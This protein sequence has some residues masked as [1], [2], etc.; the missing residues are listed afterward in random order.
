MQDDALMAT[1]TPREALRFSAG[2]RLPSTTTA[3]EIEGIV[4][5]LL[6]DLGL[7]SCAD[8]MIGGAMIK[9]IS[10]G[11]R[12]R[13]SVGIE[14]ITDPSLLFLDEPTSGLDSYSAF[15]LVKLLKE[16]AA[17]NCAVLCTIHQPSSEV[18]FL[19]DIVI[20]MKDGR[21]FYQGPPGDV[22]PFYE[23][24]GR[25]C[26]DDYNPSDY[27]MNLCQA[28][29]A[30]EL[31]KQGL[32]M[33]TPDAFRETSPSS[34]KFGSS[35]VDFHSESSFVK[36][37]TAIA[38]RE[39]VNAYR[40][41]PA[42][43]ARF[44]IT[45]LLGILYGLIFLG[46]CGKDN[47]DQ[48]NYNTHV[49]AISMV[50]IFGLFASG[51]AVM[52]SFPFERPMILREYA[53]GTYSVPA[54][55]ISKL[56]VEAPMTFVQFIVLYL[57]VY[58]MMDMQGD[59]ILLVLSTWGLGMVSNSVAMG[60]GCMV[61]DVKDVTELA[62]LMYVPQILFAG[63]FI[64]TDQIPIFLRWAQYLCSMKYAMNLVLMSEF[65]LDRDN[66]QGPAAAANCREIIES[67][68]IDPEIFYVYIILLF[69]L[70]IAFRVV[71]AMILIQKA[72]RFY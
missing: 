39:I 12:K 23:T 42:L 27:V 70:F 57:L 35:A 29:S 30:E 14:I 48:D 33:P 52:L 41:T 51:Q 13:T 47:G 62:P 58:F 54:Y 36:Q 63:F 10:G 6:E 71:G 45:T 20:Y 1:S 66:C 28:E 61:P 26:P 15:S 68:N 7:T 60:L 64:R 53:T 44:G 2:L 4:E 40:D 32:F 21:V 25:I 46:A 17:S 38:H 59:Y 67:N 31:D 34:R 11:Q 5:G 55:F 43:M 24:K 18:F 37:V 56:V 65:R 49:G 22:L 19:F 9:G 69:A 50:V 16:V 3:E 72:K 8:V